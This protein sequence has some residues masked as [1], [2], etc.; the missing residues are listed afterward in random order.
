MAILVVDSEPLMHRYV[1]LV[2]GKHG[3][4]TLEAP[5]G[6]TALKEVR[7]KP[8]QISLLMIHIDAMGSSGGI[9]LARS[10]RAEYPHIPVLFTSALNHSLEG[11]QLVVPGCRFLQKPFSPTAL[12]SAIRELLGGTG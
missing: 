5:D 12:R 9:Q 1:R 2:L 6:P 11:L 4:Q 10:V 8:D 7:S 3:F